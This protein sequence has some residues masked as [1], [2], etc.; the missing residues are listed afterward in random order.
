[1]VDFQT[2]SQLH[3]DSP[4]FKKWFPTSGSSEREYLSQEKMDDDTPPPEPDIYVFPDS[5]YGYNLHKKKWG[6]NT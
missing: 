6:E 2:Y 1:M 3:S 4:G 5:I